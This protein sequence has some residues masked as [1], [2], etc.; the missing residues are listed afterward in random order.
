MSD[1]IVCTCLD[2]TE[3]DIIE[4]VKAGAHTFDTI[5]EV[6]QAGTVCGACVTEIEEII[7]ANK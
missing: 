6:N 1:K 2:I 7:E 4:A 3:G 5:S